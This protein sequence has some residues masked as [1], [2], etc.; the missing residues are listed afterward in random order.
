MRVFWEK[1]GMLGPSTAWQ[2]AALMIEK[3]QAN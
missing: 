3:S 1:V 2:V